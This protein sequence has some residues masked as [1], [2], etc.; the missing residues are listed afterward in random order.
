MRF[1]LVDLPALIVDVWAVLYRWVLILGSLA[2]WGVMAT[3]LVLWLVF[4]IRWG[5]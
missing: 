4:G 2:L 5:W 3:A 1:W